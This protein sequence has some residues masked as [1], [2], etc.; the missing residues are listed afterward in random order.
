MGKDIIDTSKNGDKKEEEKS[1]DQLAK[2][3]VDKKNKDSAKDDMGRPLTEQDIKLLRR[4]GKG[5]YTNAL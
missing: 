1:A 2:E 3:I 4:Y 5:P